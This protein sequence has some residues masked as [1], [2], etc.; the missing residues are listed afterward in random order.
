[1]WSF[2]KW[3]IVVAI[4]PINIPIKSTKSY[5][6]RFLFLYYNNLLQY[7][8]KIIQ[9]I[10]KPFLVTN[11]KEMNHPMHSL[12]VIQ[13]L[14]YVKNYS[15]IKLE[16]NFWMVTKFKKEMPTERPESKLTLNLWYN[17]KIINSIN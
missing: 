14:T 9:E 7:N 11:S 6:V 13:S 10:N 3:K 8:S 4:L 17:K 5:F 12:F 2:L 16:V 1:M 15:Q